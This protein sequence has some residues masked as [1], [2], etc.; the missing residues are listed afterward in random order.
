MVAQ[1]KGTGAVVDEL[2][3]QGG[4]YAEDNGAGLL[5]GA[6]ASMLLSMGISLGLGFLGGML[7][8]KARGESRGLTRGIEIGRAE[9]LATQAEPRARR[10]LWWRRSG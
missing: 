1:R 3:T 7:V 9:A 4:S 10:R 2:R 8:G 6:R 5:T